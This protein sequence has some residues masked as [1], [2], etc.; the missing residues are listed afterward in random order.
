[1]PEWT[2]TQ[3]VTMIGTL[4]TVLAYLGSHAYVAIRQKLSNDEWVCGPFEKRMIYLFG[5]PLCWYL[6]LTHPEL[7]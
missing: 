7:W 3:A 1:M 6:W 2:M 4:Y 5:G